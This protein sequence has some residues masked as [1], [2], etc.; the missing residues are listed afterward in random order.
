LAQG[1]FPIGI[2]AV[3]AMAAGTA[4]TTAGLAMTAVFGKKLAVRIAGQKQSLR[5]Q[6]I[7]Q[8]IEVG[9]AFCV[10]LFGAVLLLASWSGMLTPA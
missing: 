7:A 9:A 3:I 10:L 1:I 8:I 6:L 2:A 4:L 5:A